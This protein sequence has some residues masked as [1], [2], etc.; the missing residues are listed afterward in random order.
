MLADGTIVVLH[1]DTLRRTATIPATGAST[2][3]GGSYHTSDGAEVMRLLDSDVSTLRWGN[4]EYVDMGSSKAPQFSDERL[5]RFS[6][7]LELVGSHA[8]KAFVE[9]KGDDLRIIEPAAAEAE[10]AFAAGDLDETS[11]IWI[12]SDFDAM[13]A[14]KLRLPVM[15]FSSCTPNYFRHFL[16]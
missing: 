12:S 6:E 4:L 1:D 11:L 5:L 2:R 3:Y 15:G 7:F 16:N 14:M 10:G 9:L 8:R 13:T